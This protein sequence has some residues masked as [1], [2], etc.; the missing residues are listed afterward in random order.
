MHT[1]L[2]TL[3]RELRMSMA[4]QD[5][6]D[7]GMSDATDPSDLPFRV[8]IQ[9][10]HWKK[11]KHA[12]VHCVAIASQRTQMDTHHADKFGAMTMQYAMRLENRM[13][14]RLRKWIQPQ[15]SLGFPLGAIEFRKLEFRHQRG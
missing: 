9:F 12:G 4:L 13:L 1:I 2:K 6:I 7:W 15:V 10:G 3:V 11:S 14:Y 8:Q 5:E